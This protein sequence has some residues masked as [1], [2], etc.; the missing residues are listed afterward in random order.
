MAAASCHAAPVARPPEPLIVVAPP[1]PPAL[2]AARIASSTVHTDAAVA[3]PGVTPPGHERIVVAGTFDHLHDGH[4]GM[5]HSGFARSRNV[6]VWVTDDAA[7]AAKAARIGQPV[8][9]Y[10][11]RA[12]ALYA[13]CMAQSPDSIASFRERHAMPHWPMTGVLDAAHPYA[14][15]FTLH[16][17]ADALGNTVTDATYTAIVCSEE[18]RPGCS[19]INDRRAA[20]GMPPLAIIIAPMM[21]NPAGAKLSS[22]TIRTL[23]AGSS[24]GGGGGGGGGGAH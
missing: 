2:E 7:A 17:L 6:E 12:G 14:G 10:A 13:W 3:T 16:P 1:P 15:R 21:L 20:A 5:L 11:E 8:A 22:T 24:G 18:T 19:V 4:F 9:S 23:L